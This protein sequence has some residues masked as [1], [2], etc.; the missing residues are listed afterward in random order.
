MKIKYR[1]PV[2]GHFL[3]LTCACIGVGCENPALRMALRSRSSKPKWAK[4]ETGFGASIPETWKTR[5]LRLHFGV[6]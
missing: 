6:S 2:D 1:K 5:Q 3:L 4:L